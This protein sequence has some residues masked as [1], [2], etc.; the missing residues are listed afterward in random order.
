MRPSLTRR[1][2]KNLW[3]SASHGLM[4][5][6]IDFCRLCLRDEKSLANR[7]EDRITRQPGS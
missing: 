1:V 7:R 3:E 2:V 5:T 4:E 6:K